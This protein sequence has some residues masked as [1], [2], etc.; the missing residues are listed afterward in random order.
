[1]GRAN[2]SSSRFPFG[3]GRCPVTRWPR[4]RLRPQRPGPWRPGQALTD[5]VVAH[6]RGT[7]AAGQGPQSDRTGT[8]HAEQAVT[9]VAWEHAEPSAD[10]PRGAGPGSW[11]L[12]GSGVPSWVLKAGVGTGWPLAHWA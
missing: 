1:M 10:G 5:P 12:G 2:G 3:R 6:R 8:A 9:G 4:A 7:R 11:P